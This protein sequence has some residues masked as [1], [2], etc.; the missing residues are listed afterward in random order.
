[1]KIDNPLPLS[2]DIINQA[3]DWLVILH[4][5]EASPE[6]LQQFKQWQ[7]QDPRHDQ[8]I[9]QFNQLSLGLTQLPPPL[10]QKQ[11]IKT[12]HHL[13]RKLKQYSLYGLVVICGLAISSQLPWAN[14]R[15][16]QH[17]AL[18]EVK[19]IRLEDGTQLV[20]ASDTYI[21][22]HYDQSKRQIELL[23]GEIYIETAKDPQH[24]P[25]K[26]KTS[27]GQ[28]EALGTRFNIRQQQQNS[29]V[30]VY[31]DAV[32][33]YPKAFSQRYV[34]QQG[35]SSYFTTQQVK[36]SP[37][38]QLQ[39]PFWTQHILWVENRPL[40][41][42][43]AELYRYRSGQYI[44]ADDIKDIKISGVFSLK[45]TQQSLEAIASSHQLKLDFYSDY[46]LHINKSTTVK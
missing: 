46:L 34:I 10:Q 41:E 39:Q 35:Q 7:A 15:A 5:G 16:D 19:G 11:L 4:S 33:V 43:I 24:R 1:M 21:N 42:V 45:N 14:W 31:Q 18:G 13:E 17:S 37:N 25:F 12:H 20:L 23:Q 29:Q 44:L 26:V 40:K 2:E 30:D 32:A 22:I 9:A 8:A 38:T 36:T 27:E 6:Q 28:I 3:C